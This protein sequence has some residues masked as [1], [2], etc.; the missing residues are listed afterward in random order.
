MTQV[1]ALSRGVLEQDAASCRRDVTRGSRR[2]PSA[3]RRRPPSSVPD[4]YEPGCMTRPS[5]PSDL[6][7]IQLVAERVDRLPPQRRIGRGQIDQVAVVRDDRADPRLPDP[8]AEERDLLGRQFPRA[9]LA[10]RLRE[11]LQ[12]LT[13][14]GLG[15][16]DRARQSARDR[17]M[18]TESRH[19]SIVGYSISMLNAQSPARSLA[20]S[21]CRAC[22]ARA[23]SRILDARGRVGLHRRTSSSPTARSTLLPPE[24]RPFF[25]KFRTTV[26]EH[27]ID[28]DTYRTMGFVEE[29]PRHF[30][31]MDA[32]GAVP[33]HGAAARL[34]RGGC[35]V[36]QGLRPQERRAAVAHAGDLRIG[37]ATPS[38]RPTPATRATTS[39]C[40]RRSSRT[41]SAMR[42]S[43]FT[44]R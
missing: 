25:Q 27:A 2:A 21:R 24:I 18:G 10:G 38:S 20:R 29:P 3:I 36:R 35:Q 44:P 5:R 30:L 7:A 37:S 28:P 15:A 39:S 33:V 23:D 4:V 11:D 12:R 6:G 43:R 22:R 9:P 42:F 31:D 41:T 8:P 32:Y 19:G 1:R 13:A 26:V 14:A 16:V 34:R 40:S 17:Q